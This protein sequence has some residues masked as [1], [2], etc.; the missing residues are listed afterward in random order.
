MVSLKNPEQSLPAVPTSV[1]QGL[2]GLVTLDRYSARGPLLS[3]RPQ[4]L[5]VSFR[6]SRLALC[7]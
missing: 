5:T 4:E 3:L 2:H 1:G 7:P 6:G